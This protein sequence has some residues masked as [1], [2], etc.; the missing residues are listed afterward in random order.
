MLKPAN[1]DAGRN[2]NQFCKLFNTF[3]ITSK[4]WQLVCISRR[5]E[6][7]SRK[8]IG[9]TLFRIFFAVPIVDKDLL[10]TVKQDMPRF[11]KERKPKLIVCLILKTQLN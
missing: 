4:F 5:D 10:F 1:N 2:T 11:M 6:R 9:L 7:I 8:F 3:A